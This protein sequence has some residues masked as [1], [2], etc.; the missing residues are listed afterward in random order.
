[1]SLAVVEMFLKFA[2]GAVRA[3]ADFPAAIDPAEF[4]S[5]LV[6]Y[7]VV[8]LHSHMEQCFRKAIEVR[9][10]RCVDLEVRAFALSVKDEK[11]G[12]IGL[13][14]LKHTLK[15]FSAAY[16]SGFE[17]E[18]EASDLKDSWDSVR[19][20]RDSVAHYG[21]PASL[22]LAELRL[23]YE[24]VRKVLGF[25]CNGLGLSTT[26]VTEISTSIVVAGTPSGVSL[27]GTAT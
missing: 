20:Q 11:T 5:A 21:N 17:S 16:R 13:D 7:G 12:R 2:E 4:E 15:R 26:E 24:N 9:C 18:L 22:T 25:F 27:A 19:N 1:M 6:S 23:Y 14:S 8:L 3:K 10:C